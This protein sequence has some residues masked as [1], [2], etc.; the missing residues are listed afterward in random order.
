MAIQAIGVQDKAL[1]PN[2][3]IA[4]NFQFVLRTVAGRLEDHPWKALRQLLQSAGV[5]EQVL[6]E[7]C[8]A[9][10]HFA[11]SMTD[12]RKETMEQALN[13]CGWDKL[14]EEAKIAFMAYFG[15]VYAGMAFAGIRSATYGDK[16]PVEDMKRE[17]MVEFAE[18]I[19]KAM[20]RRM[21][22][23]KLSRLINGV[24]DAFRK[25]R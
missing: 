1:D 15:T 12:N 7:T 14:P 2:R 6:G 11:V 8:E 25:Q 13:R 9:F 23:K 24:K 10:I 3:D 4:H 21:W 17:G 22:V 18:Q 20:T 16:G 19:S 5:T